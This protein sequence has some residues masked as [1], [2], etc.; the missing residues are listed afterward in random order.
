MDKFP[1]PGRF[2]THD[3]QFY[4]T[5]FPLLLVITLQQ[6][7]ALAVNLVDN[8]MLGRYAEL[9][10]SGATL[11]NQIQFILQ[12]LAAGIGMGVAVLGSQYWGKQDVAPIRRITSIGMK[13]A[14]AAG[15]LFFL[16]TRLAPNFVLGLFA[17]DPAIIAEGTRYLEI[18]CFTYII[19]AI[20]N[21][22]MYALQSVETAFI[23]TVMSL[24]TIVIN[25]CLNYCLIFGNFGFP[26]LGIVGAAIATLTSRMVELIIILVYVLRVDKKL[27]LKLKDIFGFDFAYL[28]DFV[29][30]ALPVMIT[31]ALW[32]VAQG[33]QT[34]I[35][36]HMSAT[37]I[38]ANSIATVI[39]QIFA[40]FGM[41]SAH[42]ASVT[43]GKTVGQ[44]RLDA[45]RSYSRTLQMIFLLIGLCSG[46]ALFLCRGAI[47]SL[48]TVSQEAK[49][50]AL[51]F[52]T[53]LSIT[54]VGTCYEFPVEGGIIAGG[55]NPRYQAIV[56]NL[57]MWLF[58]IP[59]AAISA[60]VFDASPIVV[61]C[62]LKADQL[63][64]CIPNSIACNRYK[65]IRSLTR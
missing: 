59:S 57:F 65:W 18:M 1:K 39:F 29:R 60:F 27:R 54:T 26:E 64:K 56:D 23:G 61:F 20:S 9:S 58:T 48:Y 53:V 30:A 63:L 22:L 4:K 19:F 6:L 16:I 14:L 40:V 34:A 21:T 8:V 5:F 7:A 38:A 44:G 33:A 28:K 62:F 46:A 50:M 25:M 52:L 45:V 37:V 42:T 41:A 12:Q 10:L 36:G 43:I 49:D 51:S 47:V 32:G 31:G 3:R 24:S 55:G 35:L 15:L 13:F 2:F 11:V 17:D